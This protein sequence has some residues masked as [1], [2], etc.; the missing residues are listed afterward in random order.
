MHHLMDADRPETP[1]CVSRER[2]ERLRHMNMLPPGTLRAPFRA[3]AFWAHSA[4]R[5]ATPLVRS[6]SAT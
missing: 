2:Y 6:A 3:D 5:S 1:D 4:R